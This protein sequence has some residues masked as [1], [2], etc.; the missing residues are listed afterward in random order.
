MRK[1]YCLIPA[2]RQSLGRTK[3][4]A[5]GVTEEPVQQE[6]NRAAGRLDGH[7]PSVPNSSRARI[8][9]SSTK[10]SMSRIAH[11]EGRFL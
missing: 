2:A 5:A 7:Y 8:M 3:A 6:F 9:R 11:I 1:Q 4:P 10:A